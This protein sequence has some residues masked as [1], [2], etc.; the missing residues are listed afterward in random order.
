MRFT[1]PKKP[2]AAVLFIRT[3]SDLPASLTA[4]QQ[5]EICRRYCRDNEIPVSHSV[6]V[7]C[8]SEEALTVLRYLLRTL[9]EEIDTVFAVQFLIYSRQLRELG[10]LCLAFQCR[11]TWIYSLDLVQPLSRMLPTITPEDFL[12]A[13]QRYAEW[14]Q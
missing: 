9:P 2:K 14:I 7:C 4:D 10:Q 5:E 3:G 12:L 8:E 6:R 1:P 11:P 13:D